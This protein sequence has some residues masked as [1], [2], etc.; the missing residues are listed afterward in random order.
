MKRQIGAHFTYE[1][2]VGVGYRVVYVKENSFNG[3]ATNV[4][5]DYTRNHYIIHLQ[6]SIG[7]AFEKKYFEIVTKTNIEILIS[8]LISKTIYL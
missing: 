2:A 3:N 8:I 5:E 6:L 1:T 4:D 7:Y